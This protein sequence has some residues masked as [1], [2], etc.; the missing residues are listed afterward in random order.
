MES[1]SP[2]SGCQ[3]VQVLTRSLFLPVGL[4]DVEEEN[5]MAEEKRD[6]C[7]GSLVSG[8]DPMIL[9]MSD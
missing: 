4:P 8:S 3:L 7:G 9:F 5:N 6:P 2:N 1:G